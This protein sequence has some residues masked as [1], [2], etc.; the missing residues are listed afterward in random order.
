MISEVTFCFDEA[1][2]GYKH[3][4]GGPDKLVSFQEE[5]ETYRFGLETLAQKLFD[6]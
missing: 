2:P 3:W 1:Y 4:R 6:I 5:L